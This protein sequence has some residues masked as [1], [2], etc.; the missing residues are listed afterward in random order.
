MGSD[1]VADKDTTR[2]FV[3]SES[4]Q[5]KSKAMAAVVFK[6]ARARLNP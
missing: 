6:P 2:G 5:A 3:Y 4:Q 1:P